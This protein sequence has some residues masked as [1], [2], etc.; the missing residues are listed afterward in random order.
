MPQHFA[1]YDKLRAVATIGARGVPAPPPPIGLAPP[2]PMILVT[3]QY[4]LIAIAKM[5][6]LN[7]RFDSY[8]KIYFVR[9]ALQFYILLSTKY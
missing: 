8:A 4:S 2:P 6:L 5:L 1:H 3:V 7:G 9:V